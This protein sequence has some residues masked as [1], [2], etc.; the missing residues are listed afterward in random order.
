MSQDFTC[1]GYTD[2]EWVEKKISDFTPLTFPFRKDVL[3]TWALDPY[4]IHESKNGLYLHLRGDWNFAGRWSDYRLDFPKAGNEEED[5]EE[6]V[7]RYLE[8]HIINAIKKLPYE[9]IAVYIDEGD[10]DLY[11]KKRS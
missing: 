4:E 8:K 11:L 9:L 2:S 7:S 3:K 6:A 5:M 1:L 10:F